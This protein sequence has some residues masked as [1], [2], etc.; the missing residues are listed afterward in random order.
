[1][2]DEMN[3]RRQT[4]RHQGSGSFRVLVDEQSFPAE[5][6]DISPAGLQGRIDA[7]TFDEI[8]ER[9]D[10]VRFGM[11][12]PL[13]IRLQWGFFDGTFGAT[14]TDRLMAEPII[15]KVIES[16]A[17]PGPAEAATG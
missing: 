10:G 6:S 8:R 11:S 5:L 17:F 16:A 3:D 12:P 7:M 4:F 13:A 14:F 2:T 15:A 1:M 9:I